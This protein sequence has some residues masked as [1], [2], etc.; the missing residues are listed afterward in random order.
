MPSHPVLP[1]ECVEGLPD[2]LSNKVIMVEMAGVQKASALYAFSVLSCTL[3]GS[4]IG[5][6]RGNSLHP[7]RVDLWAREIFKR[8]R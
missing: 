8:W 3:E 7:D 1:N 5:L 6:S 2:K 4:N